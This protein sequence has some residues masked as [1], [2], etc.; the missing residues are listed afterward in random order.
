M[1]GDG[2]VRLGAAIDLRIGFLFDGG[3]DDFEALCARRIEEQEGKTAIAGDEAQFHFDWPPFC[4][5]R[6]VDVCCFRPKKHER[7][8]DD[9]ALAG[10]DEVDEQGYV[11]AGERTH[12]FEGLRGV[13]LGRE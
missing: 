5:P 13:E 7:L 3:D 9:S 1:H 10:F 4:G 2:G 8:F 11:V 12:F 6:L